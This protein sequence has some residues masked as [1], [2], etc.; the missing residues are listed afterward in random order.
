MFCIWVHM[1][2]STNTFVLRQICFVVILFF[3]L[4]F[5][6]RPQ[7]RRNPVAKQQQNA[8]LGCRCYSQESEPGKQ[9]E[10]GLDKGS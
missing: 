3:A 5:V 1:C 6:K 4:E 7:M 8:M 9:A 10:T 2:E